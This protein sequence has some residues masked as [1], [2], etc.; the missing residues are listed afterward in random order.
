MPGVAYVESLTQALYLDQE[1]DAQSY[2][3]V[4]ERLSTRTYDRQKTQD[5]IDQAIAQLET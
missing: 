3:L 4:M 5:T 1:D 2:M